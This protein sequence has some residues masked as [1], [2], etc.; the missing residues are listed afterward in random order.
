MVFAFAWM[1]CII[2]RIAGRPVT[3]AS[4]RKMTTEPTHT[5]LSLQNDPRL[6]AAVGA[7]VSYSAQRIGLPSD[8]QEGL[9]AAVIDA[10][11][12]TFPL[13]TDVDGSNPALKV[14]VEDFQDRVEVTIE[15]AGEALPTAGLDSFC[16]GGSD[17][18]M[19]GIS[20]SLQDTRV[21][22]VQYETSHGR[23][24][25]K[26]IKYFGGRKAMA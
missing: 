13:L 8:A 14:V 22:R 11:R 24:R 1:D 26:L 10:C 3:S 17:G 16:G 19:A 5:E 2:A 6:M 7:I 20:N 23:S 12:E 18:V 21:D 4:L 9:A 15:H 25:M